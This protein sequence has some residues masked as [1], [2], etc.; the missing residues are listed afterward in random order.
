MFL[1]DGTRLFRVARDAAPTIFAVV[2][3]VALI[4]LPLVLSGGIEVEPDVRRRAVYLV[5]SVVAWR[6]GWG[7]W[8]ASAMS[9]VGFCVWWG[10][11]LTSPRLATAAVLAASVGMACD[12]VGESLFVVWLPDLAARV[13]ATSEKYSPIEQQFLTV[14]QLGTYLTAVCANG[15][16][17]AGGILLTIATRSL[18]TRMLAIAWGIW[19]VGAGMSISG[20]AGYTTCLVASSAMLFPLFV[21]WCV[22]LGRR[23]K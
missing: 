4:A 17:T 16:Y 15:L 7:A 22:I 13:L 3:I 6:V 2:H 8:M 11:K 19:I 23:L 12:L 9:L 18:P 14:Q 5:A 21:V 1:I 10:A 20:I